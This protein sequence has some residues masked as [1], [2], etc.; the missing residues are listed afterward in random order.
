MEIE[1]LPNLGVDDPAARAAI[2]ALDRA[3]LAEDTQPAGSVG[4]WRQAGL[5]D[6]VE[7]NVV[8]NG[9][10]PSHPASRAPTPS[11]AR[12]GGTSPEGFAGRHQA[13]S[14]RSSRGAVRA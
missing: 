10:N 14:E 12:S 8:P 6:A 13:P 2:A 5:Q 1:L 3:G 9:R 7:R 11:A 4:A